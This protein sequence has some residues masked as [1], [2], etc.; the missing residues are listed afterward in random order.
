MH[1]TPADTAHMQHALQLAAEAMWLSQP[2]PR[3]GCVLVNPSGHVIGSGHT[4]AVG[5]AHAEVMALRA[6][7]QAGHSTHGATAYVTLEPCAHTGRT[8]PC[9]DA[10]LA[11]G[12][13]RVVAA[14]PDPNPQVA[15]AGLQRLRAAGVQVHVG[16]CQADAVALN[17]GFFSRMQRRRPWLRMKMATS[18]DG[19]SALPNGQSQWITSPQARADGHA[20]RARACAVLTG[21]GTVRQDNPRLDVRE[22]ATPRQPHV[23]VVDSQCQTAP[24]AN[25]WRPERRR[26]WAHAV[27]TP[28]TATAGEPARQLLH[29]P[30]ADGAKV[31]LTALLHALAE[32]EVNEVHAEAG[33]ALNASLLRAGLVDEILLYQ[34]PCWLGQGALA[35]QFG[36]LQSP[37]QGLAL[38]WLEEARVGPDRR[39]RVLTPPGA[40][41][42]Q[43]ATTT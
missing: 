8:G 30:Q 17:V 4:Q 40:A 15:G 7:A 20:W 32:H 25:I 38:Q 5:H 43:G 21:Y 13:A 18:L 6:A 1:T 12:V 2:N 39:L 16:L 9:T 24:N 34:A 3:V 28:P 29:L 11:A 19:V 35:S 23:V 10:L 37:D 22:V 36:P 26:F 14:T 41:F 42:W 33:P 27:A 31:D